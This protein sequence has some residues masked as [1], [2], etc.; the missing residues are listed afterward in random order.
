MDVCL[1][2]NGVRVGWTVE[3]VG[4]VVVE[5]AQGRMEAEALAAWLREKAGAG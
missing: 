1:V 5:V 4:P 2:L 3:E